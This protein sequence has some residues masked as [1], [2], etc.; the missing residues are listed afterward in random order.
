MPQLSSSIPLTPTIDKVDQS[1]HSGPTF[2]RFC[3]I[4]TCP[5]HYGSDDLFSNDKTSLLHA[6]LHGNN[7]HQSLL[8]SLPSNILMSIGRG[9]CCDV[10]PALFLSTD[11]QRHH[12]ST[13][14]NFTTALLKPTS[15]L[16]EYTQDK[17][18]F[19]CP[20]S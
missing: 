15:Q 12:Q 11:S 5:Y 13:C 1:P 16:D 18:Y 4:K 10:C 7:I 9:R 17:L 2:Q 8:L 3:R 19:L 6:E 14:S 20:P